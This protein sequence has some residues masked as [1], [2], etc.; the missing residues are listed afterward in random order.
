MDVNAVIPF[1]VEVLPWI[2]LGVAVWLGLWL[3]LSIAESVVDLCAGG[4]D[5]RAFHA[6]GNA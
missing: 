4:P 3:L 6:L 2:A 5:K 1:I